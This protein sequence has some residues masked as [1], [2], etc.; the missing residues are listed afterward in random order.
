MSL[1][2]GL[3]NCNNSVWYL[4]FVQGIKNL[5]LKILNILKIAKENKRHKSSCVPPMSNKKEKNETHQQLQ[6]LFPFLSES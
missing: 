1:N 2:I 6:I 5:N 4:A 3:K